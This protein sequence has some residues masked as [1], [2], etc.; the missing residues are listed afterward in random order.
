MIS[1]FLRRRS[2]N[3]TADMLGMEL[4]MDLNHAFMGLSH[5]LP[6]LLRSPVG[7]LAD[8]FV[9]F[10]ELFISRN[11]RQKQAAP[12]STTPSPNPQANL[13]PPN[14]GMPYIRTSDQEASVK[15]LLLQRLM[16]SMGMG[17]RDISTLSPDERRWLSHL[18]QRYSSAHVLPPLPLSPTLSNSPPPPMNY[19]QQQQQQQM[20]PPVGNHNMKRPKKEGVKRDR[21]ES[22]DDFLIPGALSP[23]ELMASLV[24]GN[25]V[26]QP[27]VEPAASCDLVFRKELMALNEKLS[28]CAYS[29][30]GGELAVGLRNGN[31]IS[32]REAACNAEGYHAGP[33]TQLRW[34]KQSMLAS[35]SLDRCVKIRHTS[36]GVNRIQTFTG[37]NA[38]VYSIEFINRST[39]ASSDGDGVI[40]FW[41]IDTSECLKELVVNINSLIYRN[42]V[43]SRLFR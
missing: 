33:I 16:G 34:Y 36:E 43:D 14:M 9:V 5:Q 31:L 25:S 7:F 38:P 21:G 20:R 13:S 30:D 4:E 35:A 41:N 37:H 12:S 29:A 23:D 11:L 1:D 18:M 24:Q 32:M 6:V 17:N 2:L 27:T 3:K 40:K 26:Q 15:K 22:I 39:L 19:G 28:C 10:W 42:V 8:W